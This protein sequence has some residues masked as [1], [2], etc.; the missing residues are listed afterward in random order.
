MRQ[1]GFFL[2]VCRIER[3]RVRKGESCELRRIERKEERTYKKFKYRFDRSGRLAASLRAFSSD[4]HRAHTST[5][6][7]VSSAFTKTYRIAM[8]KWRKTVNVNANVPATRWTK[9]VLSVNQGGSLNCIR[10]TRVELFCCLWST[11]SEA[12]R[13]PRMERNRRNKR[14]HNRGRTGFASPCV[15]SWDS[16]LTCPWLIERVDWSRIS[17]RNAVGDVYPADVHIIQIYKST[18][19]QEIRRVAVSH[20]ATFFHSFQKFRRKSLSDGSHLRKRIYVNKS[21]NLRKLSREYLGSTDEEGKTR[22]KGTI[23]KNDSHVSRIK[24]TLESPCNRYRYDLELSK[25]D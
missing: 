11:Q 15:S 2:V 3:V 12:T 18:W 14:F 19:A 10:V 17:K 20:R 22:L 13:Y 6:D 9:L 5:T 1:P 8:Y 25:I 4:R 23:Y 21:D 7:C 24:R 16:R